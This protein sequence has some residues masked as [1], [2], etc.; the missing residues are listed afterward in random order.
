MSTGDPITHQRA[1]DYH[2]FSAVRQDL[3][4]MKALMGRMVEAMSRIALIEE[5]QNTQAA[6]ADQ[7]YERL[8]SV[9]N[10]LHEHEVLAA[11]NT[12]V[13]GRLK[14]VEVAV[15]ELH[16]ESERN[17][18]RFQAIVWL[19]GGVWAFVAGGGALMLYQLF[20]N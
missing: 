16:V 11:T 1:V 8:E 18:A 12:G 10:K 20:I 5:R 14:D 13:G 15:R 9:M 4:D 3:T 19:I 6:K 17:K 2:E 7:H